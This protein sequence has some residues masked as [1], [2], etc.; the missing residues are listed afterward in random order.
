MIDNSNLIKPMFYFNENNHMYF[1]CQLVIRRKDHPSSKIED[2]VVRTYFMKSAEQLEKLMP[3][4]KMLCDFYGARA[5][6]N[7]S[8]KDY[9]TLR[10]RLLRKLITSLDE[11][12][13][14]DPDRLLNS[15]SGEIKSRAPKWIIDIDN[16]DILEDVKKLVEKEI[17]EYDIIPTKQGCHIITRPI[18][19]REIREKFPDIDIHKNSM[20]TLLYMPEIK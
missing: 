17:S 18:D 9:S 13:D 16:M 11:N 14:A 3:E 5:Y 1:L 20:G 12:I 15:S 8:G 19:L 7:V 2:K 10:V 6:I 4:I